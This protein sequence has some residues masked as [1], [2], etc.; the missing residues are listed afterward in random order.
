MTKSTTHQFLLRL[1]CL[2]QHSPVPVVFPV[3]AN[4]IPHVPLVRL[5]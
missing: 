3:G 5:R 2:Q 4:S 1:L